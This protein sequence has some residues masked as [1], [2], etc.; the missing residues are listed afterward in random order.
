MA[1]RK[2]SAYLPL[3]LTPKAYERVLQEAETEHRSASGWG[4]QIIEAELDRRDRGAV[5]LEVGQE[6]QDVF[7]VYRTLGRL[8]PEAM[9]ALVTLARLALVHQSV[10]ADVVAYAGRFSAALDS[11]RSAPDAPQQPQPGG[12]RAKGKR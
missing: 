5:L 12:R 4:G 1:I 2:K 6:E 7:E 9:L 11:A 3:R 10:R 8:S